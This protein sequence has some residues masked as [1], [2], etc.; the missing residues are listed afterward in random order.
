LINVAKLEH[1]SQIKK[2]FKN[3]DI[4]F[5][6]LYDHYCEYSKVQL[7]KNNILLEVKGFTMFINNFNLNV[8]FAQ[9]DLLGIFNSIVRGSDEPQENVNQEVLATIQSDA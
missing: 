9:D 3:H 6:S 7:S 1:S 8:I 4:I 2:V 5:K